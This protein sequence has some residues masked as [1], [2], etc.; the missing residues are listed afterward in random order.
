[1]IWTLSLLFQFLQR[2]KEEKK[3]RR[4]N[5]NKKQITKISTTESC[6]KPCTYVVVA[7]NVPDSG[8]KLPNAC[9]FAFFGSSALYCPG[10]GI[11]F[12]LMMLHSTSDLGVYLPHVPVVCSG[13]KGRPEQHQHQQTHQ[14]K[15]KKKKSGKEQSIVQHIHL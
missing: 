3:K 13:K 11:S 4:K 10:P 14:K 2:R 15:E 5:W 9:M 12:A 6:S 7:L 8:V 1:M